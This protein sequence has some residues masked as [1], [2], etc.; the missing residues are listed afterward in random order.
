MQPMSKIFCDRKNAA[1]VLGVSAWT[2]HY[3]AEPGLESRLV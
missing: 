3:A 2:V 1:C